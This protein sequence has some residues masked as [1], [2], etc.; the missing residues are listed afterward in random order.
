MLDED[1]RLEALVRLR[2]RDGRL[3]SSFYLLSVALEL[4]EFGVRRGVVREGEH[5]VVE[6][7]LYQEVR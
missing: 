3:E 7:D 5:A 1:G 6:S 2:E 4:V